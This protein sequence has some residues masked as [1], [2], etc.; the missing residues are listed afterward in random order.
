MVLMYILM[1]LPLMAIP[2]FW[3]LPIIQAMAV[4][5]VCLLLS[6]W[7]FWL[8]HKIHKLP[9][10]TGAENLINRDVKVISK[11]SFGVGT[12]YGVETEG[13]L[14]T[15]CTEDS[16]EVGDTVTI[17]AVKGTTLSVKRKMDTDK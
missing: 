12:T 9:V 6:A 7:M 14:W 13:E 11:S 17:V 5:F 16:V 8:M 2:V 10:A 3:F 1:F 4:Y 15:A